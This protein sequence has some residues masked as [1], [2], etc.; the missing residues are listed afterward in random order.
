[1]KV[2]VI[3]QGGRE[4]AIVKSLRRCSSITE[5]H[6]LPGNSAITEATLHPILASQVADIISLCKNKNIDYV[7]I[8]PE[9]P[10][11][12]GLSDQLREAG[13]LVVG[14]SQA[15]AKL[16]GSKV[17]AKEFMQRAGVPTAK[18]QIVSSVDSCLA[19]ANQFTP[20]YVLKADGLAS[21]KGVFIC[22]DLGELKIAAQ[23]LF[24]QKIF[25]AAGT[26]ALLEQFTS[27]WELSY[28]I[29]TNGVEYQALPIAQDHKRLLDNN[30]GPNT[31]GMGTV[32][33]LKISSTLERNIQEQVILPTL[34]QLQ[35]ENLLFRGVLF[36]GLM[37]QGDQPSVLEYNV[38]LGD[39][40]TQVLLPLIESDL[41]L[42]LMA[43]ANGKISE[44]KITPGKFA[45]CVVV[46]SEGYPLTPVMGAEIHGLPLPDQKDSYSI[47][48]GIKYQ[49]KK[50]T[51]EGGRVLGAVGI[52]DSIE[53]ALKK[54]YS[55]I[56][57]ISFKGMQFRKDIG[58]NMPN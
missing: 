2:L 13:I 52:S 30:L 21:G 23:D 11:V 43:L 39:P 37:I 48:S 24:E 1:M 17:F 56:D 27:G 33:P 16:E 18:A 28:L 46:A 49:N 3:G 51:V 7:F 6:L 32:A 35:T 22:S 50:W 34:K 31:G 38:R 12:D 53:S 44:L 14:P 40:E 54:S 4:H 19:V 8:G 15:A 57:K 45:S 58:S 55:L 9:Q 42:F 36:V 26:Q 10:L 41:N 47:H 20:P 29:F 25:G 5:V